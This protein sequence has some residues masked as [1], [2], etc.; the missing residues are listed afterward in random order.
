M[1]FIKQ[2]C[3]K[4]PN[5]NL[6][7]QL[8]EANPRGHTADVLG[9]ALI[10]VDVIKARANE[11]SNIINKLIKEGGNK[12][13][14]SSCANKYKAILVADVSQATQAL[15]FGNPKFGE[16]ATSDSAVEVTSCEEGF[17]EKSPLT[18]ENNSMRD[19]ANVTRAIIRLLL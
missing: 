9:L 5:P 16:D 10:L 2:T 15:Q 17:G 14:L 8:I 7:I 1:N 11:V 12:E 4:T 19:V 13:A 18:L 3:Q 6:C